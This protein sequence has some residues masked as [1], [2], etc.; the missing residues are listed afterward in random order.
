MTRKYGGLFTYTHFNN[1][2]VAIVELTCETDFAE[3]TEL[4]KKFGND[5]AASVACSEAESLEDLL[6]E[7]L[8]NEEVTIKDSVEN[9]KKEFREKIE[10][11]SFQ[12]IIF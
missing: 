7:E 2:I 11:K 1:K 6:S 9:L 8:A 4:F 12:K 10:I 3:R 5:L